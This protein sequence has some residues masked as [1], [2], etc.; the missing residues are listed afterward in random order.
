MRISISSAALQYVGMIRIV[1][2]KRPR[3]GLD[4]SREVGE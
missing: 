2:A 1:I 3:R 4:D